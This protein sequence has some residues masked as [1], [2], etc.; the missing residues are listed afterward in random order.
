M[1]RFYC[2]LCVLLALIFVSGT[3]AFAQDEEIKVRNANETSEIPEKGFKKHNLFTGGGVT[4]S[5]YN[6]GAVLGA[7]PVLGY[8]LNDYMDAGVVINYVYNGARDYNYSNDKFRQHVFGPGLFARAYPV[9]FL[10]AHVQLEENFTNQKYYLPGSATPDIKTNTNA[11]S[12]L[13][14]GGLSTG[15]IKGGTTFF[16]FSVLADIL[17]NRNSPYVNVDY[18]GTPNEKIRILPVIR[19]GVNV[20]LFQGRYGVYQEY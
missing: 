1:K 18:Y 2:F 20:G 14:G 9:P 7:S 5:F 3:D 17:K 11:T 19:A 6:G 12:L 13:V 15:R 8:K 4:A 10:F 16:Y